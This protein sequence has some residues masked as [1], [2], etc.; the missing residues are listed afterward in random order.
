MTYFVVVDLVEL[1]RLVHLFFLGLCPIYLK[2]NKNKFSLV[3]RYS[4]LLSSMRGR[5][6]I[7][8]CMLV[9]QSLAR[10]MCVDMCDVI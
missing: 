6:I 9:D 10:V 8:A 7:R 2:Q 4:I 5:R 1:F 3:L